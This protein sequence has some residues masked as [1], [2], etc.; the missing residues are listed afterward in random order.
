MEIN[1]QVIPTNLEVK[2]IKER[3]QEIVYLKNEPQLFWQDFLKIHLDI[4]KQFNLINIVT[5]NH[6]GT[7][8]E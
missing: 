3:K 6:Y 4:I 8:L 7:I 5:L 1:T 2:E